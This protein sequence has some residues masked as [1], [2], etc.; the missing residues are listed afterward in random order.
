MAEIAPHFA[1]H[2]L[3]PIVDKTFAFAN[4]AEAHAYMQDRKNFGKILL[5]P[6]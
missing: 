1:S 5:Y 3:D 2:A 4:A 6:R